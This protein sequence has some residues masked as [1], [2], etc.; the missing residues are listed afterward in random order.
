LRH[1]AHLW[2]LVFKGYC[3]IRD[4]EE[5]WTLDDVA[6]ALAVMAAQGALEQLSMARLAAKKPKGR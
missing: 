3:T 1:E 4:L 2:F 6:R 5:S